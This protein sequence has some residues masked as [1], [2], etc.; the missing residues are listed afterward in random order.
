MVLP[1]VLCAV[2]TGTTEGCCHH[3]PNDHPADALC[4]AVPNAQR[5]AGVCTARSKSRRGGAIVFSLSDKNPLVETRPPTDLGSSREH[6]VVDSQNVK[7]RLL[8]NHHAS[9]TNP[10]IIIIIIIVL[11]ITII[12]TIL[13]LL[14]SCQQS[15]WR[16]IQSLIPTERWWTVFLFHSIC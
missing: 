5:S 11:T 9:S 15:A 6:T 2:D 8:I 1:S 10:I 4:M 3:D 14:V 13:L 12:I 16:F 7:V